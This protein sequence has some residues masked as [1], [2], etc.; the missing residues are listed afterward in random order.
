MNTFSPQRHRGTVKGKDSFG[1]LI[2][3]VFSN[4]VSVSLWFIMFSPVFAQQ[5]GQRPAVY[6]GLGVGGTQEAMG[7]AAVGVRND[8]ACGYWNPAG[9]SGIRGFQVEDQY[10]LLSEGRTLNYLG[11]AGGYKNKI[12]YGFSFIYY[13]V[14]D[15]E[16]RQGP[17]VDPDSVYGDSEMAFLI[18]LACRLDSRW[19]LGGNLKF[20]FNA[21]GDFSGFGFGEDIGVQFRATKYT[22]IGFMLQDPLSFLSYSNSTNEFFQ[23]TLRAG[24][25]HL[26]E[27][28]AVKMNFDLEWS[29]DLGFRPRMGLEWRPI[30]VIALRGGCWL[31]GL[32]GDGAEGVAARFTGG[33]GILIPTGGGLTEF[34]YTL[35]PDGI[36]PGGLLHQISLKGKFL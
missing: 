9:L 10:T 21:M 35:L 32:T 7:G 27:S 26:E 14:G 28:L 25:A 5:G 24:I 36:V 16:A 22:T 20:F 4:C 1:K 12:F 8:P 18:S 13:G 34:G 2:K 3:I 17:S 6:M 11:L 31:G 33:L 30:E 15:L 19:S 23:P 29:G